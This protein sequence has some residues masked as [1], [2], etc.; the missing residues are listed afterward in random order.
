MPGIYLKGRLTEFADEF[1]WD[2]REG[3]ESGMTA[4]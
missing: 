1:M 3:E 2:G 4:F